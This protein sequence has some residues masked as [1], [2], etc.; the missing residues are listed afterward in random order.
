MESNKYAK[1][2]AALVW[3]PRPHPIPE[4][5][6][7]AA[8][9]T[10]AKIQNFVDQWTENQDS[11]RNDLKSEYVQSSMS[12]LCTMLVNYDPASR[13]ALTEGANGNV[14][15]CMKVSIGG[16]MP[17]SPIITRGYDRSDEEP[18]F[19]RSGW[20]DGHNISYATRLVPTVNPNA[21]SEFRVAIESK[22]NDS[23]WY[24]FNLLTSLARDPLGR[25]ANPHVGSQWLCANWERVDS[26]RLENALRDLNY[27]VGNLK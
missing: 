4:H 10:G 3:H 18:R 13:E 17:R 5:V 24:R 20:I 7:M 9:E 14:A 25:I 21:A 26:E 6:L 22:T 2:Y 19:G 8:V 11:I 1:T 23:T 27:A 15:K 16:N 12:V